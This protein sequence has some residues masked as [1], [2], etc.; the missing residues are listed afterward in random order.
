[1]KI[2]PAV[3]RRA[4]II[5]YSGDASNYLKGV[6]V[7]VANISRFLRSDYGGAWENDEITIAPNNC[8]AEWLEN[9]LGYQEGF[10]DYY[11]I[12]YIG[13]GSYDGEIGPIYWLNAN[14]WICNFWF[15]ERIGGNAATMLVSDSCQ[16]IEKLQK[17]G[18][19]DSRTFSATDLEFDRTECRKLYNEALRRLPKG[20]FVT[21]SSVSPG[22]EAT[23]DSKRGGYYIYSLLQT[24][25]SIVHNT[26]YQNGIYGIGYIHSVASEQVEQLTNGKQ[27]PDL[28]GY[29][30]SSQPPFIVKVMLSR[31]M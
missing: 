3:R 21:A 31:F 7:D 22:E 28:K 27:T 17:G 20:M 18:I 12:F 23:E 13:H 6:S 26:E 19:L 1:M 9:H 25:E 5:H 29:T 16:V 2:I 11:L 4:L 14:E 15:Q 30:R 10:V 24:A 8:S